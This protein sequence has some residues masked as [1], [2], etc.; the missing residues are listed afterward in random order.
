MQNRLIQQPLFKIILSLT[1]PSIG[2][3]LF[4]VV[5]E[6][7]DMFWIGRLGA[8]AVAALGAA[9]FFVW[10]LRALAQTVATGIL[11][12][13]S[14]RIGEGDQNRAI[15]TIVDGLAGTGVFTLFIMMVTLPVSH[16]VFLWL[17]LD[18]AVAKLAGDY[19]RIMVIGLISLY[20]TTSLEHV[21]RGLGNTKT[22][23]IVVGLSLVL[24]ILLDPVFIFVFKMGLRGAAI[25][26]VISHIVASIWLL[27]SV[28][29]F[30]PA[31]RNCRLH[32]SRNF[33]KRTFFSMA[34]IGAPIAFNGVAFS[35]IYLILSG[36]I[37]HF[38]SKPLAALGIGHR[39]ETLPFFIA[40]GF[41]VAVSTIVGQ[42]LGAGKPERAKSAVFL[43]LKIA[44]CILFFISLI[45]YFFP[46]F[47]YRFFITDL[48]VIYHGIRY[49]K[50]IAVFET[51]LALEIILE[52]A[53]SGSGHT[54]P[55]MLIAIPVTFL[56]V[57]GAWLLGVHFG[58][59]TEIIWF[60]IS[61]TTFIKGILLLG[62]FLRGTWTEKEV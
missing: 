52:G 53:F 9:S 50:W 62:W 51:F 16:R 56:R 18:P 24:N 32:H 27:L 29:R 35:V 21:I 41:S 49:L 44:A 31:I 42:N 34:R 40:W 61:F 7:A 47:L 25:A 22:P 55:P 48:E 2:S 10:M 5:F 17:N 33:L 30:L 45:F 13:V 57:P 26:T 14:R 46:E 4:I 60:F 11:A 19:V 59:G 39:I 28:P 23:M 8:D 37:S 38:G 43:S 12:M 15:Q 1:L 54:K 6:I 3:G 20:L 58:F 36:I